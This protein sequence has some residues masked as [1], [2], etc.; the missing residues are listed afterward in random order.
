[1]IRIITVSKYKAHTKPLFKAPALLKI[2]DMID[3]SMLKFYYRNVYDNLPAHFYSFRILTQ[4]IHSNNDMR[5]RDQIH[6]DRTRTWHANKRVR[7]YL[8]TLLNSTPTNLLEKIPLSLL[9]L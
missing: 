5:N 7:K 3:L 2:E 4:D 9:G 8:P 6:I 1:M